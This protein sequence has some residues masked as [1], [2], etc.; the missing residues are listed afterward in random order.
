MHVWM[1]KGVWER[2]H[3]STVLPSRLSINA[4]RRSGRDDMTPF[5]PD[6]SHNANYSIT[7]IKLVDLTCFI[8]S[9]YVPIKIL[10]STEMHSF[11]RLRPIY[12]YVVMK[13]FPATNLNTGSDTKNN[14][15]YHES[16]SAFLRSNTETTLTY[17]IRT[18]CWE[19]LIVCGILGS[20]SAVGLVT[21]Y[22]LESR[23]SIPGRGNRF[24]STPQRPYWLQGPP[25][26]LSNG[27]RG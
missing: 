27:Y 10:K 23:E 25:S 6:G 13:P 19:M 21:G 3:I 24:F 15:I 9:G 5:E 14:S 26:L 22:E 16:V 12:K 20:Y 18:L 2:L 8:I 4:C 17:Y 1:Y 7:E 11:W